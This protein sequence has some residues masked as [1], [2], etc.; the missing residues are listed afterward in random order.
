MATGSRPGDRTGAAHRA[1]AILGSTW[2]LGALIAVATWTGLDAP[3]PGLDPSW[4]AALNI[5]AQERLEFGTEVV[6]TSGPLGFLKTQYL[7]FAWPARL[8]A[9]YG[10]GVQLALALSLLW[11]ARRSFPLLVALPLVVFGVLLIPSPFLAAQTSIV[12]VVL[13]WCL[14]ALG[15]ESPG[16]S[17]RLVVLGGGPVAAIE[18]LATLNTG[19][20]VL[21]LLVVTVVAMDGERRRNI[22]VFAGLFASSLVALWLLAG[23]GTGAVGEFLEGA[24]SIVLG[25]SSSMIAENPAREFDHVLAPALFAALLVLGWVST[26][27]VPR[28]S[29]VAIVT[30][31]GIVG[32]TT[33]KEGL[34]RH[35]VFHA[36]VAYATL[37]GA[38]LAL[39]WP[40]ELRAAV[41]V[42]AAGVVAVALTADLASFPRANPVDNASDGLSTVG[43]L[44]SSGDRERFLDEARASMREE[45]GL[46]RHTLE[47]VRDR[48]VAVYPQAIGAAYAYGLEWRPLPVV[49]AYS[50]YTEELDSRNAEEL[51]DPEGP[52][53]ILRE[54]VA[55]IDSR[56]Q[57]FESPAAMIAMLCNFE[58]LRTAERWQVLGRVP[59][60]CG[61]P[62]PLRTVETTYGRPIDVPKAAG[63][64]VVVARVSGVQVE[65]LERL[66][67]LLY[68]SR[69]REIAFDDGFGYR[70]VP[71]TAA[72]GL[73][74]S[75]PRRIDFPAPFAIAPDTTT[76]T[77][78]RGGQPSS[79]GI[80]VE[81]EAMR[82]AA[83]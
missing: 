11:A 7:Y 10:F 29:R 16:W 62:T 41:V 5:A 9:L 3:V 37:L 44:L 13:V 12:V 4:Q 64:R 38:L 77:F 14:A 55:P 25:Y 76:I 56:Y 79:D 46:D 33:L 61:E 60:R 49:Q 73:L 63:S 80:S 22:A 82:V 2:L 58:P 21:A 31:L 72:D 78:L 18:I 81:F 67:T 57:G 66:G 34:V 65:G 70:L 75:A 52:E 1:R 43:R 40:R 19:F 54:M 24:V 48:P 51:A 35:D 71:G 68:R 53:R 47:L 6:F 69:T 36:V 32:F 59:D 74:L 42:V 45:Y 28:A 15:E 8:A 23:Q 30:L 83:R 50:A 20:T 27:S 26:K 39:R 17:R